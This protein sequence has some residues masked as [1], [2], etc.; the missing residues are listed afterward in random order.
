MIF[1]LSMCSVHAQQKNSLG[2]EMVEIPAGVFHMGNH[3]EGENY[4]E[5]PIHKVTLSHPFLM[6]ATEITNQQYE[7]FAPSHKQIRGK[8]GLSKNDDE[9]V[10]FV[11]YDEATEFC[12]WLS[13]KEGKTYRLP[14]E[15]EWEYACKAGTYTNFSMDDNLP[16]S[17]HKKQSTVWGVDQSIDLKVKTTPANPWGLYDM[18]GNVEEWCYDWYGPY[19]AAAQTDPKGRADGL[20]RVTRGGSHSTPVA[21]LR[22]TNRMGMLPE[23]KHWLT[24]F[25]VVCAELPATPLLPAIPPAYAQGISQKKLSWDKPTDK[26]LFAEPI[27]YVKQ[28]AC[29][30]GIPFYNHNHCPAVTWCDNG[31]LLA[32]WFSTNDEAGR[33]MT[34]LCSRL[35]A[36]QQE[37]DTPNE[38]FKVP[39]RNMTGS[40]LFNDGN[41]RLIYVNGVE[42]AGSWQSLSMV[43]RTSDDNGQTWSRPR[44]MTTEH[45]MRHQVIA[46]MF[47]TRE[48]WLA[49]PADASPWGDGGTALHISKDK[50]E[51]WTDFG[52]GVANNFVEGGIGGSIA[53]I[54]AGVVQLTN[55]DFLALGRGNSIANR[56]SILRMPLSISQDGGK[57]WRYSASEFPPIDGGQ[58]LVLRRLNEGPLLLV[59]FT[60]HPYRLK[61]GLKGMTFTGEDGKEFI[62]YGMFAALSF[63]EGKTWPVKKLLTD[64]KSRFMDGGAWTGFFEMDATHAEPRGYL[65]ATQTPDNMIHLMSSRNHYRFNLNW[66]LAHTGYPIKGTEMNRIDVTDHFWAPRLKQN[67]QVTV[68]DVL[69][70]C[71]EY[72]R[73]QNFAVAAELQEGKFIGGQS[74]DD[75]DLFKAMEAAAYQYALHKD[76]HLRMYMDSVINLIAKAQEPDGYLVTVMRINKEKNLPWNIKSPRFS[77][78]KWSHEL[79]NFGHLYEAAVA[80][81]EAT[82]QKNLLQVAENNADLL[83]RTF[84]TD[85]HPNTSVGGCPEVELGLAKLYRATGRPEYLQLAKHMLELRG[86][87]TKHELFLDYDEGRNPYFF[88]DYKPVK[89]FNEALGHGVRALYLYAG[90]ADVD[91]QLSDTTYHKALH[92]LWHNITKHKMYITGGI[93]SRHKGEAFGEN[94]ELPNAGAYCETCS[95]ISNVMWNYRMF[96]MTGEGKYMD[97]CERILYNAFLA[98]WALNGTEYNY[99]NPLESDGEYKYNKGANKR[100]AWFET[101]C[102]P[103]NI[104]RFVPQV[105]Q[106]AYAT[107]GNNLYVNLFMGGNA[108]VCLEHTTVDLTQQTEYPWKGGIRLE[109]NPQKES[110]FSIYIRIP[111]WT[112]NQ[113]IPES[114]LYR[115]ANKDVGSVTLSVNGRKQ[116]VKEWKNGYAVLERTWKKGDN[117]EINLPMEVRYALANENITT[118]RQQTVVTWGPLVYCMEEADNGKLDN[119]SVSLTDK[120]S[121]RY[122]PGMLGGINTIQV[123]RQKF[124]PYFT[125]G[126]RGNNQMKVWIPI[127]K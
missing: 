110:D 44:L 12:K 104:S 25:R 126:N 101:S 48:G 89:E 60:N 78:M 115:Y 54:H 100:Q 102:C 77:Y 63:D 29:D 3:G 93:G 13:A 91:A 99:V 106:M 38:F 68:P 18:H 83:V 10:I 121:L 116:A 87:S 34:I 107:K 105:P 43:M 6:S 39:D 95:S 112:Q 85:E 109:V 120:T 22:S 7:A 11:S 49:Q 114:D 31:D 53:G 84:L 117:I 86:D 36:G 2:M 103:T 62:G 97:V 56:D 67:T 79:Y 119:A 9:A 8:S 52:K 17:Y 51:T 4:D 108:S 69:K 75:S 76:E 37:W 72:G 15:A 96:L 123:N 50:G 1:S 66:L 47:K 26:A 81:Y 74:W 61:N 24:G 94:Y 122:E 88:Q 40:S 124:I 64:G 23:D 30:S 16:G 5:S 127:R 59:S 65:A 27:V 92:D 70:K 118:N 113:L 20:F 58:R 98:G 125:W 45:E 57:T 90:M 21:F 82:G 42:A 28:P 14:T 46:G 111:S 32:V 41:G 33:E 71:A 80:H 35:R 73:I 55:G 19:E